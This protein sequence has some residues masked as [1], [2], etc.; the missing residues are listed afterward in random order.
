MSRSLER[1]K[2]PVALPVV[3]QSNELVILGSGRAYR[4]PGRYFGRA[5]RQGLLSL[6]VVGATSLAG[7]ICMGTAGCLAAVETGFMA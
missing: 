4:N 6:D 3:G 7:V 5:A 1:T 2:K